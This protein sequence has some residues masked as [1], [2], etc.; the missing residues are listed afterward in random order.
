MKAASE[1]C[2]VALPMS[3]NYATTSLTSATTDA[4]SKEQISLKALAT[5]VLQ[6]NSQRNRCATKEEKPRNPQPGNAPQKLRS[7]GSGCIVADTPALPSWCW[8][9]CSCLEIIEGLGPGCIK[10][11]TCDLWREEWRRLDHLKAC[12]GRKGHE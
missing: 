1:S 2:T 12:P 8:A 9:D 6:R 10:Q 4:T 11:L 7:C 3:R 5:R